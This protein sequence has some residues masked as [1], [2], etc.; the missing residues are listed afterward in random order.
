MKITSA[1]F[2]LALSVAQWVGG[3]VCLEVNYWIEV[4]R[5]MSIEEIALAKLVQQ[6]TGIES[7]VRVLLED[8]LMPRG[9][10]YGDFV[11]SKKNELKTIYYTVEHQTDSTFYKS[12]AQT[13]DQKNPASNGPSE[14]L[15]KGL[16][17]VFEIPETQYFALWVQ[18]RIAS[19]FQV[20]TP[21]S[22]LFK[23][24]FLHPPAK[25]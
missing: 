17:K 20:A 23:T 24:L 12:L 15:L 7:V 5:Q 10:F 19:T 11:F 1:W 4:Q 18:K 2:L 22:F 14:N 9:N 3:H 25:A 6:K 8:E 21:S 16:F 13:P